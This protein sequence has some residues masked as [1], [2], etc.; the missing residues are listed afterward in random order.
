MGEGLFLIGT[1]RGVGKTIVGVALV[2]ILRRMG[3][4]ATM[5]TPISTGGSVESAVELLREIGVEEDRRLVTPL[6]YETPAAPYVA[7]RVEGRPVDL[8]RVMSAYEALRKAGKFVVV[9]GGGAM[10]P[11]TRN[12]TTIDLLKDLGLPSLIVARTGRGTLNHCLLTLRMMLAMGEAPLGFILNGFGQHGDGFAEALN[13]DIV[14]ELARPTPVLATLE[15]RPEYRTDIHLF[16]DALGKETELLDV[17]EE[18][19]AE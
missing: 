13:P 10:V 7:G 19:V 3:V 12:V 11:L 16:I 18:L 8:T 14:A 6:S 4:D 17:L 1:D 5:M 9:E 15:W 2:A